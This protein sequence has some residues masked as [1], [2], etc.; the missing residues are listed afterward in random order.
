MRS[1]IVATKSS[2]PSIISSVTT[3]PLGRA[4]LPPP[5]APPEFPMQPN[6]RRFLPRF[7]GYR[8]GECLVHGDPKAATALP[9][10]RRAVGLNG[11]RSLLATRNQTVNLG[12]NVR[13]IQPVCQQRQRG[14]PAAAQICVT[15][16]CV[17]LPAWMAADAR[18]TRPTNCCRASW[19]T[20]PGGNI[21]GRRHGR[22]RTS[23]RDGSG[24]GRYRLGTA[25]VGTDCAM[26]DAATEASGHAATPW[27][28]RAAG[29]LP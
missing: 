24:Q 17:T 25:P 10:P 13:Q 23:Y 11:R 12:R 2:P 3:T 7:P 8:A 27:A 5:A 18:P 19:G 9:P 20:S 26:V 14:T 21:R 4:Y 1:R 6:G 28:K 22:C 16:A 15:S 29:R